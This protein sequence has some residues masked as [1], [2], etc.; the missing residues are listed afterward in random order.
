MPVAEWDITATEM[1]IKDHKGA[2]PYNSGDARLDGSA[3]GTVSKRRSIIHPPARRPAP[4]RAGDVVRS[5]RCRSCP[6]GRAI[7]ATSMPGRGPA[8]PCGR[9]GAR[10]SI[11]ALPV[12]VARH[13][14]RACR[15]LASLIETYRPK[16]AE[17]DRVAALA[18]IIDGIRSN[19]LAPVYSAH[20]DLRGKDLT[21]RKPPPGAES[22]ARRRC[23]CAPR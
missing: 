10:N 19:A 17:N 3:P 4:R 2:V 7:L 23:G 13:M 16:L 12:H 9:P 18:S 1:R 21:D 8:R 11:A 5:G 20:P 14:Q 6:I 15:H 22:R